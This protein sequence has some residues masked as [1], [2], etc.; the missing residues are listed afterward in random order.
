MPQSSNRSHIRYCC[1]GWPLRSDDYLPRDQLVPQ[2]NIEST[3]LSFSQSPHNKQPA[4]YSIYSTVMYWTVMYCTVLLCTVLY[5][6]VLYCTVMYCTVMYCTGLLCTGLL[7][8]VKLDRSGAD[9]QIMWLIIQ[10]S[11]VKNPI[12]MCD[13]LTDYSIRWHRQKLSPTQPRYNQDQYSLFIYQPLCYFLYFI[14]LWLDLF[15]RIIA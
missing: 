14:F 7:C 6:Y 11:F 3:I 2:R 13:K 12:N 9:L 5:C 10:V 8:T 15:L 1:I 4:L